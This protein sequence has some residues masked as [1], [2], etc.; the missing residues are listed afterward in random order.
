MGNNN[1]IDITDLLEY[2]TPSTVLMDN[3]Y[4]KGRVDERNNMLKLI[5]RLP[6]ANIERHGTWQAGNISDAHSSG[7]YRVCSECKESTFILW[8]SINGLRK[9][10]YNYCPHCG[11][12]M[13]GVVS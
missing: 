12:K 9:A 6:R 13:L 11:A 1:L 4:Y 10:D 5:Q 7:K 8:S 3:D 2:L